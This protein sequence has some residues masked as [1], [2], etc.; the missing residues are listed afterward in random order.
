MDSLDAE[1]ISQ[2]FTRKICCDAEEETENPKKSTRK[3]N[4]VSLDVLSALVK[5]MGVQTV[6]T[7][8]HHNFYPRKRAAAMI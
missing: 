4:L 2:I 6:H 1:E 7:S 8:V 3:K 5:I